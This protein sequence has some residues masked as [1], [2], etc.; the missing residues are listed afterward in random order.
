MVEINFSDLVEMTT[1]DERA[2]LVIQP[3]DRN[4]ERIS[5]SN[6]VNNHS[7]FQVFSGTAA[8]SNALSVLGDI[9]PVP[10]EF[11]G[12]YVQ[13]YFRLEHTNYLDIA[14]HGTDFQVAVSIVSSVASE[15]TTVT[16]NIPVG[17]NSDLTTDEN[18]LVRLVIPENMTRIFIQARA[19]GGDGTTT[20]YNF[21]LG[22]RAHSVI[23]PEI[24]T[25]P[26]TPST[27]SVESD[28][29]HLVD[30]DGTVAENGVT[31]I[32]ALDPLPSWMIGNRFGAR[33]ELTINNIPQAAN[34]TEFTI[35]LRNTVTLA[36]GGSGFFNID[37]NTTLD[38]SIASPTY[39]LFHSYS[40][41]NALTGLELSVINGANVELSFR[42]EAHFHVL[43]ALASGSSSPSPS[44]SFPDR[45]LRADFDYELSSD[46]T[47]DINA[48]GL[49]VPEWM[50]NEYVDFFFRFHYD[51]PNDASLTQT[52]T[53]I[54]RDAAG[55]FVLSSFGAVIFN[56]RRA[57][58]EVP[59]LAFALEIPANAYSILF[60]GRIFGFP[61]DAS[62]VEV[63]AELRAA[64]S[65]GIETDF[66]LTPARTNQLSSG[67]GQTQQANALEDIDDTHYL[68]REYV[69]ETN[70]DTI[71]GSIDTIPSWMLDTPV[72]IYYRLKVPEVVA[73][74]DGL[75]V[76][77]QASIV[78]TDTPDIN[79]FVNISLEQ[80]EDYVG[81][82][83]FEVTVPSD[84]ERIDF[85]LNHQGS[86]HFL[87]NLEVHIHTIVGVQQN[88]RLSA[89]EATNTQQTTD[90][91][92]LTTRVTTAEA[93][94]A[95]LAATT[96][97]AVNYVN[98]HSRTFTDEHVF[99]IA[100]VTPNHFTFTAP[101]W[102]AQ[103]NI[104]YSL[105]VRVTHE[106]A[107]SSVLADIS[108]L[109]RTSHRIHTREPGVHNY[110]FTGFFDVS[111][112]PIT[113]TYTVRPLALVNISPVH[114]ETKLTMFVDSSGENNYTIRTV[115]FGENPFVLDLSAHD[116]LP[117]EHRVDLT[118]DYLEYVTIGIAESNS[119]PIQ[120]FTFPCTGLG[121]IPT[122]V[123]GLTE[124]FGGDIIIRYD[125]DQVINKY[126]AYQYRK[127]FNGAGI[128]NYRLFRFTKADHATEN[129]IYG[130]QCPFG[131][132]THA[133]R[134]Y[135]LEMIY[136]NSRS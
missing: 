63:S 117:E 15:S 132:G 94:V 7:L 64:P 77:I 122:M 93:D 26:S 39:E 20:G 2:E 84:V 114:V 128:D 105:Y 57:N 58:N 3:S 125:T 5:A 33:Y 100:S 70:P 95:I 120:Y 21:N 126:Y 24:A 130:I 80:G 81:E 83:S 52:F 4:P 89:I 61:S 136:R 59:I 22:V 74:N 62:P 66:V 87:F 30:F 116:I 50:Q 19:V 53:I 38:T 9:T 25:V 129:V 27:P 14:R 6:L 99:T 10:S 96:T 119:D 76:G 45:Y 40:T 67:A 133:P 121:E 127:Y 41:T 8:N 54:V 60:T 17:P 91:G 44:P 16:T 109:G 134:L 37:I 104:A 42:I 112:A 110:H 29:Y 49:L 73:A 23:G 86:N 113:R 115:D 35:R 65:T 102:T 11:M 34:G 124:T 12:A 103:N 85:S 98:D 97:P 72:S 43:T 1:L 32:P 123:R 135:Y 71:A 13:F 88:A 48:Q 55:N 106:A 47:V 82:G 107:N 36:G 118:T 46:S 90:I 131:H 68:R 92:A 18:G 28:H 78:S 69:G 108:G 111:D 101:A 51:N 79:T 31:L 56:I 75:F